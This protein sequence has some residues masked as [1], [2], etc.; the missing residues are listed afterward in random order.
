MA[1]RLSRIGNPVLEEDGVNLKT[2][3]NLGNWSLNVI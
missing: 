3:L 2:A 1:H